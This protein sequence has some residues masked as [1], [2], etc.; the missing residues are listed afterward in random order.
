MNASSGEDECLIFGGYGTNTY[1]SRYLW[2]G[3][4]SPTYCGLSS[5]S[6][7]LANEQS[8]WIITPLL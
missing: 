5:L 4:A 6:D 2:G 3:G 8:V 1:P 7:Q